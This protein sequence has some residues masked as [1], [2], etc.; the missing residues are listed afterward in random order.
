M[1]SR[2]LDAQL[3]Q[4]DILGNVYYPK[5]DYSKAK[6]LGSLNTFQSPL[7]FEP[8]KNGS[9]LVA[10]L[11]FSEAFCVVLSQ[12]CD[13]AIRDGEPCK[14]DFIVCC[15]L[16]EYSRGHQEKDPARFKQVRL[17]PLSDFG[18][19]YFFARKK[20]LLSHFVAELSNTFSVPKKSYP[21]LAARK[22][23]QLTDAERV[24]FK[25]KVASFF[26]RATDEETTAKLWTEASGAKCAAETKSGVRCSRTPMP[27]L[28]FC[29][30]HQP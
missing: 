18:S 15:V 3:R 22:I 5:L 29:R 25:K 20:P 14:T 13:L 23:L 19:S 21:D 11:T 26:G 1:Y 24:H 7:A 2:V 6:F 30:Q 4:G 9:S 12:C 27:G 8:Q 16:R 28:R 10:Q 17:N